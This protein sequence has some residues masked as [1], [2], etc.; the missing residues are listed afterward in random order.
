M[1]DRIERITDRRTFTGAMLKEVL[2]ELGITQAH[3][4]R[5]IGINQAT[6]HKWVTDKA[7]PNA[8]SMKALRITLLTSYQVYYRKRK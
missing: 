5:I 1:K 3:L 7:T 4:A 8:L 6:V 2:T